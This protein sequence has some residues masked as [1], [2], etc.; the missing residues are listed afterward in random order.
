[1]INWGDINRETEYGIDRVVCYPTNGNPIPWGGI[2]RI[3]NERDIESQSVYYSG[4][5]VDE[6]LL[7]GDATLSV[8][9]FTK[10]K[11]L[12]LL[13]GV[14]QIDYGI[15]AWVDSNSYFGMSYRSKKSSGGYI[16]YVIP[17]AVGYLKKNS[18]STINESVEPTSFEWLIKSIPV[19]IGNFNKTG[20]FSFDSDKVD[21]ET[22]ASVEE[23]LY[24]KPNTNGSMDKFVKVMQGLNGEWTIVDDGDDG[25]WSLSG[26]SEKLTIL[27]DGEFIIEM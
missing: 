20:L 9:S 19:D 25:Y 27:P 26:P 23:A 15:T 16:L 4:E 13:C 8:S 22:F 17:L 7:F 10:P 5:I 18:H 11:E 21:R 2:T 24:G 14:A 6:L 1:M 12:E 3:D